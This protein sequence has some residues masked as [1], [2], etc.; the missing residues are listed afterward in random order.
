[1]I[2]DG[3]FKDTPIVAG[4]GMGECYVDIVM[5]IVATARMAPIIN[6]VKDI[7]MSSC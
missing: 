2:K 4:Q 1:M 3:R 7:A 6:E 5:F